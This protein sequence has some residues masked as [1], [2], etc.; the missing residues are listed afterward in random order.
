MLR[1]RFLLGAASAAVV[2][3]LAGLAGCDGGSTDY[4][5][6]PIP[7]SNVELR[8][9]ADMYMHPGAPTEWWWHTGT[10]TAGTRTFGFEINL[11]SFAK[12]N[13]AFGQVMLTDVEKNM[14]YQRT[15]PYLPPLLYDPA[16][17]A[18]AD[19]TKPWF[20]RLGDETNHLSAID[21]TNGGSGYTSSPAVEI[22]GGGGGIL[23]LAV[24][25]LDA[26]GSVST[27]LLVSPGIGFTSTPTITL[28][29]GGGSGATAKAVHSY[30]SM[31]APQSDP[32][33]NMTVKSALVDQA[34]GT[35]VLFDLTF[36]QQ[37]PPFFVWGTGINPDGT[38]N[39]L[40]T[41]NYYFSLTR[42]QA[43]GTITVASE[44]FNVSGTTWM[45]HEY[46]AFGTSANPVKWFLQDMQLDNGY[47]ISNYATLAGGTLPE[48]NK[49]AASNC[50]VQ[51]ADGKT[52]FLP[53]FV[54]PIGRTWVSPASN[55]TYYMQFLVEIPAF[56]ASIIVNTLVDSQEFSQAGGSVYEGVARATG[57]FQ[58][59][60]VTGT[61][62]NEQAL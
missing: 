61:A 22:T 30:I 20:A 40:Q 27:I 31:K 44:K 38:G 48:L 60:A 34:T 50:T 56:D 39:T 36:S 14:H 21:V 59:Q 35:E 49:K 26:K 8:L 41:R 52:Y 45:D 19:T 24:A 16:T 2:A 57:T 29:G 62:W 6:Q 54:T 32:T 17:Y 9:P 7:P 43:S 42:L 23:A 51:A 46:G 53:S 47:S 58:S 4:G 25:V 37:G 10:L 11:S 3:P 13:F 12:D 33:K 15:T 28:V 5:P 18:E 1:R 55:T